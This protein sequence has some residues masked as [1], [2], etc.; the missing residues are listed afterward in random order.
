MSIRYIIIYIFV[1][2][3]K[4]IAWRN[5]PKRATKWTPK[6]TE[7]LAKWKAVWN[8]PLPPKKFRSLPRSSSFMQKKRELKIRRERKDCI[9]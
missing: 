8:P 1:P 6:S 2:K 5:L 3:K 4:N 7:I 9:L